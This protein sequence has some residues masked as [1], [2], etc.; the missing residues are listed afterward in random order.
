MKMLHPLR[1]LVNHAHQR[2]IYCL[3]QGSLVIYSHQT[4]RK[5]KKIFQKF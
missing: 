3:R 2:H 5:L 1:H 4:N